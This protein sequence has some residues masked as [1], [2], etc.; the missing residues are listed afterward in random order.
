MEV[1][2]LG[3]KVLIALDLRLSANTFH[4][5]WDV[6]KPDWATVQVYISGLVTPGGGRGQ[7]SER[8]GGGEGG[9]GCHCTV[10]GSVCTTGYTLHLVSLSLSLSLS[11]CLPISILYSLLPCLRLIHL[12]PTHVLHSW[13]GLSSAGIS[14][15]EGLLLV[16][17][18][19]E[20]TFSLLCHAHSIT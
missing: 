11:L 14:K 10:G 1:K 8:W 4:F 15:S 13:P 6:K 3:V 5:L 16:A 20:K 7:W 17:V 19:Q 2:Q 9:L 12:P 18:G